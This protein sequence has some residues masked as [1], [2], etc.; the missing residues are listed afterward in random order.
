MF[1]KWLKIT[2]FTYA[3]RTPYFKLMDNAK[4]DEIA[5]LIKDARLKKGY[6]QQQLADLTQLNL[7]SVQ[8]IEKAEV[9]PR[10][11]NLNLLAQQ[12]DLDIETFTLI[13]RVIHEPS[14][15]IY[16]QTGTMISKERKLV[17]SISLG[18]LT[19]LLTAAFLSQ[20]GRF[21]ETSFELFLF[22]ALVV[23]T[24]AVVLWR[25]WK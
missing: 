2:T 4:K 7:R 23:T 10:T 17:L 18:L 21:P 19:I 14:D 1:I 5:K 22:L 8:R 20:S 3:V 6:S 16:V 11:Y 25:I 12:L 9:L 24:N 15:E 13:K